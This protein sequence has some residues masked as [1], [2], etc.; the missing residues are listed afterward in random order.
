[1][2]QQRLEDRFFGCEVEIDGALGD[3]RLGGDV[4]DDALGKTLAGKD[5]AGGIENLVSPELRH[6]LLLALRTDLVGF[7]DHLQ[8]SSASERLVTS[9]TDAYDSIL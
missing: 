6:N 4:V 5:L 2:L 1:M 8:I 9:D 3:A 7:C